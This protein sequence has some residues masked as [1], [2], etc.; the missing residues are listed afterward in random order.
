MH[1]D[2]ELHPPL[3]IEPAASVQ[4]NLDDDATDDANSIDSINWTDDNIG[5]I[6]ESDSDADVKYVPDVSSNDDED[7]FAGCES[8]DRDVDLSDSDTDEVTHMV[9]VAKDVKG[10]LFI[11]NGEREI[12]LEE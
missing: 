9:N 7:G 2:S 12:N 11:H 6:I 5:D 4:D 1:I 8:N 10:R 3:E